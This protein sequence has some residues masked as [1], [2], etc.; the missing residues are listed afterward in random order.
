MPHV[1]L[2]AAGLVALADLDIIARRTA[3]SGTSR[4]ADVLVLC[5]GLH[6]QQSASE[7]NRGEFPACAAMTTGYAFRIENPATV[8]FLQSVG[9]TGQLSC[10]KVEYAKS[11]SEEW[12]TIKLFCR[13]VPYAFCCL[14]TVS[15]LIVFA[16]IRDWWAVT[17][18]SILVFARLCNVFVVKKRVE[19]AGEWKGASEP[20]VQ[21]D[22][23]VLLSQD[24][25]IRIQG[26]VDDL[27]AVT[28]G[29]WLAEMTPLESAVS[30]LATVLVYLDAALTSNASQLGKIILLILLIGSAGFLA[31]A[32]EQTEALHMHG[33]V[34][35]VQKGRK[36]YDRRLSMAK[37]L[38]HSS[39]RSDWA[40]KLGL[41]NEEDCDEK[42]ASANSSVIM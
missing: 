3:L 4:F 23:L 31:I 12:T 15:T 11:H 7:L 27:K 10:V 39:G 34:L 32:N 14:L 5:P 41:V 1:S 19:R 20:G 30:A 42:C 18:V 21:G 35:Q 17:S 40:L 29:Q 16:L 22:L 25:W 38:I 2:D 37:E 33:R 28:S 13:T 26:A 36:A 24:R 6:T 8:A 9:R